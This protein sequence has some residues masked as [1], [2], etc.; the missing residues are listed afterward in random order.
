MKSQS[1]ITGVLKNKWTPEI[2]SICHDRNSKKIAFT[3]QEENS[4]QKW[5][6]L[7]LDL[8]FQLSEQL[9][10]KFLLFKS[11]SLCILLWQLGQIKKTEKGTQ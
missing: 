11:P 2:L 7:D 10:D 3:S 1:S 6:W 5:T 4:H 9:E 8:G